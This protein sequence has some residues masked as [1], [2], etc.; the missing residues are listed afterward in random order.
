MHIVT[1]VRNPLSVYHLRLQNNL[2]LSVYVVIRVCSSPPA[3][4]ARLVDSSLSTAR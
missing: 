2:L 3:R 4:L 1:Q